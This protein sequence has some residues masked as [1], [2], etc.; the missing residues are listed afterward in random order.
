MYERILISC[1]VG[2]GSFQFGSGSPVLTQTPYVPLLLAGVSSGS[3]WY[4][5]WISDWPVL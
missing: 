3:D 5:L 4:V 2:N 1:C